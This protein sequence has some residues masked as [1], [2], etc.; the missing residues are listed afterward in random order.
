M[1]NFLIGGHSA[2]EWNLIILFIASNLDPLPI[3]NCYD[4]AG[5]LIKRPGPR[6]R[7]AIQWITDAPNHSSSHFIWICYLMPSIT[8]MA[9]LFLCAFMAYVYTLS[10]LRAY[11]SN[12][13][14]NSTFIIHFKG[15]WPRLTHIS[16]LVWAPL[17]H[18]Y[19]L[20]NEFANATYGNNWII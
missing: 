5:Y 9:A 4:T 19:S 11:A 2:K 3:M 8:W 13:A 18:C 20:P 10:I 17:S 12:Y 1:C 6:F 7:F 14:S 16:F 15:V